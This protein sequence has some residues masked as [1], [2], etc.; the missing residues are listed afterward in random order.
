LSTQHLQSNETFEGELLLGQFYGRYDLI[1]TVAEDA[2]FEYRLAGDVGTG[3]D[4]FS[5]PAMEGLVTLKG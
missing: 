2:T 1:V 4:S 5:D 3:D